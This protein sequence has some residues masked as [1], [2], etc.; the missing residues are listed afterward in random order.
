MATG[1]QRG[2]FGPDC[3]TSV[4]PP[5]AL[6]DHPAAEPSAERCLDS[7]IDV[8]LVPSSREV[9]ADGARGV[10]WH[11]VQLWTQKRIYAVDL[12]MTCIAVLSRQSGKPATD[13]SV[14]GGRLTGGQL[15]EGDRVKMVYPLP[16]PGTQAVF[17]LGVGAQQSFVRTSPLERVIVR[18]VALGTAAREKHPTWE[19]VAEWESLERDNRVTER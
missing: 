12:A 18:L 7:G 8:V 19:A 17:E 14:V 5:P 13:Q 15:V 10:S 16:V 2:T 4:D 1:K 11:Y 3:S 9:V 6:R